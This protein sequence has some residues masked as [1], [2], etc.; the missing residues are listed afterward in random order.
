M[1]EFEKVG[2]ALNKLL[3]RIE[4]VEERCEHLHGDIAALVGKINYLE[5]RAN[6]LD[7]LVRD[8]ATRRSA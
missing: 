8:Q 7:A 5:R 3:D 4:E 1:T 2:L 6:T